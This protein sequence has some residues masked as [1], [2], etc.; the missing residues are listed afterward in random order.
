MGETRSW[1]H[2]ADTVVVGSRAAALAAVVGGARVVVLATA[3]TISEMIQRG[4]GRGRFLMW[5]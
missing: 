1:D 2:E 5:A 3:R 4:D